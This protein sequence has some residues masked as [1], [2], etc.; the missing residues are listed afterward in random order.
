MKTIKNYPRPQFVR[1]SWLSL[2]GKWKFVF[3]DENVGEEKQ[4]FNKFPNF[5]EILVPFTYETK[6][7]GI[8]DETVHENI[9]Y[10]NDININVE[11]NKSIILHFEGSDFVTKLW[12]NGN[13]VG[14][15]IGGYHRFSFDITKFIV[16]GKNNFTIKVEDSLSKVQPRG[17]QRY[18]NESFKCWYIQTTGIWKT[19]WIES[20]SKNHI[21]SVKNTPDY[22]NKNI[23]IEL[24]TNISE[25]D[26]TNFEIETEILFDNKIVNSKKQIIEDKIL[27]YNVNIYG[28]ENNDEI[29][30]WSPENPNLYDINYKLYYK[31]NIIDEVS[32]YFGI[33]KISIE[34]SKIFLN[35]KELYLKMILDQGYW[36]DS[37]LTP[38]SEEAIIKDINIV[39]KYGYNGIR[40]H[41]KIEDE[42][43]L[44]YC[45]IN[46][47][48]VWS[49]MANCYEFND[50]SIE[51]FMNEWIKVVKQNYNHPSIIT[52]VP[53]NESWGIPNVSVQKNEQNFANSLYYITKS[54]D[55]TRPVI[56]NDGWEHTI[57]DIITIHDYKQDPE[58]L[59]NEYNDDNLD[60]LNNRRAYNTIHKL[61]SENYVYNGQPII[62][63]EYGGITL[64]SDKGWVYGNPVKSEKEFLDRFEKL[65]DAI[66]KTKYICGYC[67]TQLTD[68]Q[69]ESNGLVYDD[70]NDKFSS[71][72]INKIASI[73]EI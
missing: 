16:D 3:D 66:I 62:M 34:N 28:V 17:K 7:S 53:I 31:G 47:I 55:K 30:F 8:N 20:V 61:F 64:N 23:E 2:N 56:S 63:S 14:M 10:S 38:P 43:F 24:V 70:R 4:F 44:Y 1:D 11:K 12:I 54:I 5:N 51:Y 36:A 69:Q 27:K 73:N 40:K 50:K 60:V 72:I 32:S 15:N 19:I 48:L 67:Y 71:E 65:N 42:R 49:E 25:K 41:Q 59:Y 21:V 18:K 9:W 37:H 45:D 26:I 33:R 35:N 13:Y 29:N 52:W 39:K 68:V 22:D 58:L 46:G 6:M 57:S